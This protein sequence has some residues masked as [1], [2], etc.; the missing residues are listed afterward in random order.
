[1][2]I[3][4]K[5]LNPIQNA[6]EL[7]QIAELR[8]RAERLLADDHIT[9]SQLADAQRAVAVKL[10]DAQKATAEKLADAQKTAA[11]K[12][13]DAQ[14]AAAGHLMVSQKTAAHKLVH[15]LQV[16]QIELEMQNEALRESR[17]MAEI[18]LE[19]YAELFDFAPIAYFILGSG[20]II[21]QTNFRGEDLLGFERSNL[22]GKHFT[23]SVSS[24]FSTKV[25]E[26]CWLVVAHCAAR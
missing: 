17:S 18:A 19:R 16:Y 25:W 5:K 22:S 6:A 14:K 23:N 8:Q 7:R 13:A 2:S 1:M 20:G 21:R 10:A 4:R 24:E 26:M 15:E 9:A 11:G 3:M 12:L